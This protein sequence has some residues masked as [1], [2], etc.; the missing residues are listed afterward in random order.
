MHNLA[1]PEPPNP[2]NAPNGAKVPL[3]SVATQ[4]VGLVSPTGSKDGAGGSPCQGVYW[5]PSGTKPKVA[6]LASHYEVDFSE[7][8]LGQL[9][10]RRGFGF[11]G[12]NT[13]Y[14]A[15]GAWFS[16]DR[17]IDD[18]ATGARWL[19][20]E[21]GVDAI[22]ALGNSG[23]A[24]LMGAYQ[25]EALA[26]QNRPGERLGG[27]CPPAE[28]F[29]SLNAHQGRPQVLTS[30]MDASVIDEADMLLSDPELDPFQPR[31]TPP[32][33]ESF[34][35]RYRQ[36]QR[37]RNERITQ[38]AQ[39]KLRALRD[40]GAYDELF[41]VKRTWADLRFLDTSL[42]PSHREP[43]CYAG[44]PKVANLLPIGLAST[45]TLGTWLEMWSLRSERAKAE[46]HLKEITQPSLVIQSLGDK[47]CFP[48]DAQA[49][50]D[51]LASPDKQ[52]VWIEGDHYLQEPSG[53]RDD[54]ADL[55]ATW[56]REH[57]G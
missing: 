55:I 17:A 12:W 57:L 49:I 47:G 26:F 44:D 45:C 21:A 34:V 13:R 11:L 35:N 54:V 15:Q 42:D 6:F 23:G 19:L 9:L 25:H 30:W 38:W 18:I 39:A 8:Y 46:T 50:F 27:D 53:A 20:E 36:A 33:E 3:G 40:Q 51:A 7:H 22:V 52:L 28:L 14:R 29:I 32:F 4:W 1:E 56:V 43:G 16:F 24:S 37:D 2:S 5:F 31:R 41:T 48:S 10:A